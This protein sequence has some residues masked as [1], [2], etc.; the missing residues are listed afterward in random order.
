MESECLITSAQEE[1][2]SQLVCNFLSFD[3]VAT[4][5]NDQVFVNSRNS[6]LRISVL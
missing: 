4:V 5:Y 2:P 1:L 6:P 3:I